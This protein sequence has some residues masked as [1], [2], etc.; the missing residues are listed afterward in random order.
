MDPFVRPEMFSE[1][2]EEWENEVLMSSL[3]SRMNSITS[4]RDLLPVLVVRNVFFP[5]F[6]W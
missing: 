2:D 5:V 6:I 4:V 1:V 3:S